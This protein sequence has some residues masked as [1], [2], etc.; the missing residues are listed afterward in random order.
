M[1]CSWCQRQPKKV[2]N[3]AHPRS[4]KVI[5]HISLVANPILGVNLASLSIQCFFYD[6]IAPGSLDFKSGPNHYRFSAEC[7]VSPT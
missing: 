1:L 3:N 2:Y 6:S 4:A 7:I 5:R